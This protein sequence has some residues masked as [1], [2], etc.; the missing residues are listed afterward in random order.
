M[1]YTV[2]HTDVANKGSITVED[3]TINQQTSLS[4]PGRNTTAYGTAIAENFLHLLEN[5]A[6]SSAPNNPTEGQLWYDNTPGVDQLKLYDG[7]TWISASGLKKST[8]APGAAQS[9]TGDL[10]VDTD[11]QQLYL[12]TGAGWILVGPTFSDGLSTGVKPES[13][14]GTNNVSY[15]CLVVEIS[16]KTLAIYSTAAFTPKTT[17]QGFTTISPGF[18]LSTADITGAGAGKYYGV[19]EKAEALV[20]GNE[21]VPATNFMRND[22]TSQSLFPIIVK[23]NGGITVG[24]SSFFTVGVEGQAGIISHQTSGSNIDVRVNNNGSTTTVMRID[25]TAKVGIN[26][27]S[28]DQAL[29]VTGNIQLSNALLVEGTTDA[30]TISTGSII[31]KGGV[32]IAKKLFVGSDTNLAG[33]TT[34]ANIVPNANTSRNLGTANEQWLNVYS[35]N[36]IGNLTGNVTGTVSGRSGST[37]KLASSTTFQMNGDVSAPSFTFD[38]QDASTKT[39]TTTISNTFVANKTE[40]PSSLST[41]ELLINRVTGDTGVYKI[42]RTNLFKAIPTLP[43]GMITPFGGDVAPEDWVLCYGQEVTIAEYQNLFNV[44]GYNFKDQSLV[45]AGKFALPD[46]RGRFALGKDNMGGG[47]ANVVTSAAA[48]TMGAVEGQQNQSIALNNL[49]E[50]EHDLRGPSG[51]Q[52]YTIRDISG[53]PNDAQ[54]IQYDAPTGSQAGQAYPTSGGVLTNQALGTAIDIMNPY[55]TVNYIIYAGENTA[56]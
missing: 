5:F 13:I 33:L 28:P 23:N 42:S 10:W 38:G 41:D 39:F 21:T 16:A 12:F 4:L 54:G 24:A 56:I 22:N 1:A 8:T 36:F 19:S 40:V 37:D 6:N 46:L 35:Q 3:N 18:N 49:P 47:S 20:I 26:N 15:T 55:M 52:Y 51:D 43:I 11:N 29:D 50:H 17:I 32:G 9:V 34:T 25:S 2:N 14:V 31:T 45:A 27:L 44:I 7:T 53:V 48:D 30:A